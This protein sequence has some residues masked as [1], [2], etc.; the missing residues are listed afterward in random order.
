M[1]LVPAPS[2]EPD[3]VD[4]A[5]LDVPVKLWAASQEHAG[6]LIRE[7]TLIAASQTEEAHRKVPARLIQLI[8]ALNQEYGMTS[9]EQQAQLA[10]AAASGIEEIPVLTFRVPPRVTT[11]AVEL[12][13]ML[14][15][16]DAYCRAGRHLLT[17]ATPPEQVRFRNWY[18]EE[19]VRQVE[20]E[21]P[22]PWPAVASDTSS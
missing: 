13:T 15:E 20:G 16:A 11:A 2:A 14:D 21:A 12:K 3:L 18:L 22:R 7:F 4:V 19:F 8:E 1:D 9:A 5:L 6:E 10:D 17:L